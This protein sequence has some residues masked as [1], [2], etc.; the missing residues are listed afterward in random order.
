MQQRILLC[1]LAAGRGQLG[2]VPAAHRVQLI[3]HIRRQYRMDRFA[4]RPQP[5]SGIQ[6][7]KALHGDDHTGRR[8]RKH[9]I[10]PAAVTAQ[11]IG[12]LFLIQPGL[13][14]QRAAGD[15][16]M[17][18]PVA[19]FITADLEDP[20]AKDLR[21]FRHAGMG[22]QRIQQCFHTI[23]PQGGAEKDRKQTALP[24][25]RRQLFLLQ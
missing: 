22:I 12:L 17:G 14:P 20:G 19:L 23:Q 8:F 1:Q 18:Q 25:Q 7:T 10:A 11:L 16:Q 21:I 24:D 3:R 6:R 13:H 5:L 15:L 4:L 2:Q 9:F